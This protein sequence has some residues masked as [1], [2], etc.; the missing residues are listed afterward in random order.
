MFGVAT[1]T[2]R[3]GSLS[4]KRKQ[5]YDEKQKLKQAARGGI[6]SH[7]AEAA[8]ADEDERAAMEECE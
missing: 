4:G 1:L 8:A 3:V 5:V 6:G 2:E 7:R